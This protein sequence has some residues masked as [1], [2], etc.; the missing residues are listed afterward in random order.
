MGG[1][2]SGGFRRVQL[3]GRTTTPKAAFLPPTP[4]DDPSNPPLPGTWLIALPGNNN[5]ALILERFHLDV[6]QRGH[7]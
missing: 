4:D 1:V 5:S 6:L 3:V 2:L 7:Y